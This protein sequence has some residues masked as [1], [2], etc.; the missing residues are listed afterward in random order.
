MCLRSHVHSFT[1]DENEVPNH[2]ERT[3]LGS[4]EEMKVQRR[5]SPL[6]GSARCATNL[7]VRDTSDTARL[8]FEI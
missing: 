3:D 8:S 2:N 5:R 4:V 1:P 6:H 7:V